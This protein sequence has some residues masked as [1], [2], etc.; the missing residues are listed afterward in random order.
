MKCFSGKLVGL[1]AYVVT[2]LEMDHIVLT[3]DRENRDFDGENYI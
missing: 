2:P 3:G 1:G